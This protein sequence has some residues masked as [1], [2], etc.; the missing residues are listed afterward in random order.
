MDFAIRFDVQKNKPE[1]APP[2]WS[3]HI[4]LLDIDLEDPFGAE[5]LTHTSVHS[6]L[7]PRLWF[8]RI[9][10]K[11]FPRADFR[12]WFL[13][14]S[15]SE[16]ASLYPLLQWPESASYDGIAKKGPPI[17]QGTNWMNTSVNTWI[18]IS[19]H[20][21]IDIL[22]SAF[23]ITFPSLI[24]SIRP[25]FFP[26]LFRGVLLWTNPLTCPLTNSWKFPWTFPSMF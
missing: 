10:F 16:N 20:V 22:P 2:D 18:N 7:L 8:R 26:W 19:V 9:P 11:S 15:I 14:K 12:F 23:P 4:L 17:S 6:N 25:W 24:S 5:R 1:R 3:T 13:T 21:S